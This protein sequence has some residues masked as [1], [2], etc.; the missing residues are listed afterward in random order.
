MNATGQEGG[1][2]EGGD[3]GR[4]EVAGQSV[5]EELRE[6]HIKRCSFAFHLHLPVCVHVTFC[7]DYEQ[8]IYRTA[9][10]YYF[11]C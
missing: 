6:V 11:D 4:N 8:V 1:E 5:R 7:L 2:E 10:L 3:Q 9:A